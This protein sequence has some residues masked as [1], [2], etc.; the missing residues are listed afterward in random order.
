MTTPY[1]PFTGPP[2]PLR[3]LYRSR[4]QVERLTPTLAAGGGMSLVWSP[5]SMIIDTTDDVPGYMWCRL[6]IGFLRRGKDVPAPLVAGRAPDRVGVAY[7]DLAADINGVP[8]VQAGDRLV[9]VAGPIF[10]TFEIRM[11]PEVAQDGV[12]GHHIEVQVIEVAKQTQP[13]SPT[14]FPGGRP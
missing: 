5:L 8:L 7:Y 11:V 14:P 9:C 3:Y 6:D 12:G 2:S 13:G 1:V 4:V 10:G